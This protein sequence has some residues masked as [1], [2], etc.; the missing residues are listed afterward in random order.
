MDREK[1]KKDI[2]RTI[3]KASSLYSGSVK[4]ET[5]VKVPGIKNDLAKEEDYALF[6][7]VY[8]RVNERRVAGVEATLSAYGVFVRKQ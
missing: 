3:D 5:E 8:K 1:L 7:E 4:V 6:K 2:D